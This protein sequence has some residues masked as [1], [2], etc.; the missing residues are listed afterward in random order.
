MKRKK[1]TAIILSRKDFGESDRIVRAFSKEEG[2]IQFIARGSRKIKSKLASHIEP[3]SQGRYEI[4][5]GKTFYVLVGGEKSKFQTKTMENIAL[6]RDLSYIFEIVDLLMGEEE[7]NE[8]VFEILQKAL[9]IIPKLD[10][11]KRDLA[12]LYFEHQIL[13]NTGYKT[14]FSICKKCHKK[15]IE[16]DYYYGNFE[17]VYCEKCQEKGTKISK[18]AIKLIRMFENKSIEEIMK[19]KN[20]DKVLPEIKKVISEGLYDILPR[21]PKTI[22]I[23]EKRKEN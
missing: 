17:G 15:L 8:K 11:K 12:I 6:Y 10:G 18:N 3:F 7:K 13:S 22:S 2:K 4:V 9:Q 23:D 16:K 20:T 14:D 5:P 1:I 21:Q 19:I